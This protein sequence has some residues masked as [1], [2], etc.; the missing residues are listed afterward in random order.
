V[1]GIGKTRLL[2]A[3]AQVGGNG[4]GLCRYTSLA[5]TDAALPEPWAA[6]DLMALAAAEKVAPAG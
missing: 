5:A 2:A 3:L 4:G 6:P 1:S